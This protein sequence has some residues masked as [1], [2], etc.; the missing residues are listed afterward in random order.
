VTRKSKLFSDVKDEGSRMQ[1]NMQW[2]QMVLQPNLH[3]RSCKVVG[4]GV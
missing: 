2:M 4:A 3:V 1:T